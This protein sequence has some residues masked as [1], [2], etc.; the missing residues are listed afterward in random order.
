[1]NT[2]KENMDKL[3]HNALFKEVKLTIEKDARVLDLPFEEKK[4]FTFKAT[5]YFG[6]I[7]QGRMKD[8]KIYML[9]HEISSLMKLEIKEKVNL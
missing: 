4:K 9:I 5:D 8:L 1:M 2:I 6:L 3:Y 7:I